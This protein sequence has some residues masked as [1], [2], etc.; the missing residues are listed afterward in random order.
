M[1]SHGLLSMGCQLK[2]VKNTNN[3]VFVTVYLPLIYKCGTDLAKYLPD[4][5]IMWA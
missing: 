3:A 1:W 5:Y 2:C 4:L